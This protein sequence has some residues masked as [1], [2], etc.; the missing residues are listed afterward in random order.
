M[1]RTLT[2]VMVVSMAGLVG[3][4][5]GCEEKKAD[6]IS[7]ATDGMKDAANKAGDAMK[8]AADKAK[9]AGADLATKATDALQGEVK[10]LMDTAKTKIDALVKGGSGLAADKKPE[11]DKAVSGIQS[12]FGELTKN[13]DGLKGQTGEGLAKTLGELKTKGTELMTTVKTTAEKFGIKI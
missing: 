13:F 1:K 12:T 8:G 7:K 11:F 6:P 10:N 4:G 2:A 9:A 5:V 3:F